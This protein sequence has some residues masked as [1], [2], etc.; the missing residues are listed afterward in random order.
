MAVVS[1][2]TTQMSV[3]FDGHPTCKLLAGG[4]SVN[5]T[6]TTQHY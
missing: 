6:D 4:M 5:K 1:E 2:H 3:F